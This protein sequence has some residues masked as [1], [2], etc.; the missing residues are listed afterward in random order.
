[1]RKSD[2]WMKKCMGFR[3]KGRRPV[4]RPRRTWL[5]SASDITCGIQ[6]NQS[7]IIIECNQSDNIFILKL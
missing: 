5:E 4:G 6:S 7:S 2:D 3:V 1:M